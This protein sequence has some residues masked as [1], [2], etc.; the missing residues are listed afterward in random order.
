MEKPKNLSDRTKRQR[1]PVDWGGLSN[2]P[3]N[4][5]LAKMQGPGSY[6]KSEDKRNKVSGQSLLYRLK[7]KD[8]DRDPRDK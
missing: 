6:E 5:N 7:N 3:R 2:E 4:E 8:K 1:P